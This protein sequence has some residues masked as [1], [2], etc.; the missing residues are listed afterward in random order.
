MN[1]KMIVVTL[2]LIPLLLAS[3]A[4]GGQQARPTARVLTLGTPLSGYI[5]NRGIEWFGI[6]MTETDILTVETTSNIN[7]V[8][9]AYDE[10]SNHIVRDDDSGE[11]S[12]ARL[13]IN[14]QA[15]R[16]YF[17]RVSGYE[18][19]SGSFDI[20]AQ[21]AVR[22]LLI[23]TPV[24]VNIT[25]TGRQ[26]NGVE[27]FSIR[28]TVN[29]SLTVEATGNNRVYLE[30][31]DESRNRL[32]AR[33]DQRNN[34]ML[35]I[36]DTKA[37][38]SYSIKL[39]A[40]RGSYSIIA[41]E[42]SQTIAQ[43]QEATRQQQLA[44]Q[45]EAARQQ[46]LAQQLPPTESDF[47]VRQ[48]ADNTITITGYKGASRNAVIPSTLYGL[49]VTVIGG[50][51]FINKNLTSVVIPNTVVTIGAGAFSSGITMYGQAYQGPSNNFAEVVIPNSVT[52]IG[53]NA[54]TGSKIT[55]LRL[56]TG[57]QVIGESAFWSCD[58]TELTLSTSLRTIGREAFRD[59]RI[60][61][62]TI[63][64]TVT[65]IGQGAFANNPLETLVIPASLAR[66]GISGSAFSTNY[67][68]NREPTTATR[69]TVP[70]NMDD[71]YLRSMG[72]DQ[73]FVNFY[74]SQNKAAGTYVKNG[75]IWT[76]Q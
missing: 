68:Y 11:G 24:S 5:S 4:T 72:F 8:L 59:N 49:R 38:R 40:P 18:G 28:A 7:T 36:D 13:Q 63:P 17:F 10:Y 19:E 16:I 43:Q 52:E 2:V 30:A 31:Y 75:P 67:A 76:R 9:D 46:Q 55:R 69:I 51:A 12:N 25:E 70:A 32:L 34:V 66:S 44:Q 23:G 22:E 62:L 65:T 1:R 56:G 64:N 58:I 21:S 35:Q 45:Q 39:E 53:A 29:G 26:L 61:S 3:C 33:E 42:S 27:W 57:V 54:F 71:S 47:E 41:R 14:A 73:G 20:V 60:R 15:G 50:L 48:N 37:G 74:T 6:R